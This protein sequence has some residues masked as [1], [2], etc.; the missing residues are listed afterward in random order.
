MTVRV[1]VVVLVAVTI[2]TAALVV[3]QLGAEVSFT[4]VTFRINA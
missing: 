3:T 4:V 2:L 1:A